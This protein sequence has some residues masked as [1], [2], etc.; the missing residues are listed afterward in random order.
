MRSVRGLNMNTELTGRVVGHTVSYLLD[1]SQVEE[2]EPLESARTAWGRITGECR[3]DPA[4]VIVQDLP[5]GFHGLVRLDAI[6][7]VMTESY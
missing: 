6:H 5:T 4:L 2:G 7:T 3:N 1:P